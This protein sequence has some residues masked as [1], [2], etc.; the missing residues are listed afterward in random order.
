M[1]RDSTESI[2]K[3][4]REECEEFREE[5]DPPLGVLVLYPDQ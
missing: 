1:D 3:L 2:P 4:S 5:D